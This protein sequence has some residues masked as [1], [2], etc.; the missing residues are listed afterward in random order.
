MNRRQGGYQ[1]LQ[2]QLKK[3]REKNRQLALQIEDR[4]QIE[5]ALVESRER[6]EAIFEASPDPIVVYNTHGHVEYVN[7]AF[8]QVFGWTQADLAGQRIPFVPPEEEDITRSKIKEIYETKRAVSFHT[9]RLTR[10]GSLRDVLVRAAIIKGEGHAPAGMVV[11]LTDVTETRRLEYQL[12]NAQRMESL[13]TLA[14]GI[15][16]DFNNLLMGI[17]GNATLM[18]HDRESTDPEYAKL[19]SIEKYVLDGSKLTQQLLGVAKGGK[20]EVKPANINDIIAKN[21][22]MFGRTKKE[23]RIHRKFQPDVWTVMI[24]HGQIEQVLLNLY[25][26]AWQ[27]MPAGGD[28]FLQTTNVQHDVDAARGFG[29]PP[30]RYVRISVTDSGIG[31]DNATRVRI[32]D[33]FFTTKQMGRGTGLGLASA[34]GITK[35][36]GGF[37]TVFS[38]VDKGTTF[39]VYLPAS[40]QK[41]VAESGQDDTSLDGTETVLLVDDEAMILEV[42]REMLQKIGYSVLTADSGGAALDVYRQNQQRVD[43]VILDMIMPDMG[44]GDVYQRLRELNPDIKVILSS[45]YSI[46]GMASDI[47]NQGCNG[48]IQKPFNLQEIANKLK[49]IIN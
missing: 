7:P 47:L 12:Q 16:H 33:P 27:A 48:F 46:N 11:N 14:G 23:I 43:V 29:A 36:H 37:I 39:N 21:A 38:Q 44:G 20:Y 1:E 9:R 3:L 17:L 31:M 32:F 41:V 10:D 30:G 8:Q 2:Q 28:L 49:E 13:G 40:D 35:N 22:T 15:A 6:L 34:Y 18:M 26:N 19:K 25:V 5:A 42:G 45:G 24:D 4:K